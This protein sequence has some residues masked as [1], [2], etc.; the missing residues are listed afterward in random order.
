MAIIRVARDAPNS[1]T[2]ISPIRI[3]GNPSR[4]SVVRM[5]MLS[6]MPPSK[7]AII[8]SGTPEITASISAATAI[9]SEIRAP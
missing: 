8:A 9:P 7:P 4:A 2:T 1:A 5:M 3:P 6:T